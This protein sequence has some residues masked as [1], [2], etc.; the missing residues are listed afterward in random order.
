MTTIVCI[1]SQGVM[2]ADSQVTVDSEAGG[3]R[4]FRCKKL[5]EKDGAIIGLA[6]ESSPGMVFLRWY[7]TARMRDN[8]PPP[9]FENID[10]DFTALVLK[11][12]GTLWEYDAWCVG[13]QVEEEFYAI[14]SGAK[15]AL[16]AL[17][18]MKRAGPLPENA[19]ELACEIACEVDPYTSAPLT[20]K[21][22]T[23]KRNKE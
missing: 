22:I 6:G 11:P 10:A 12:D 20:Q 16:G 1:P 21:R 4:K 14:G 19:A 8:K 5:Y 23:A 15:A 7:G 18:A 13:E 17:R 9:R 3:S 2:V